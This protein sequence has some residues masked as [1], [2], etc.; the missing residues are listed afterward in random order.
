MKNLLFSRVLLMLAF[1]GAIL[2]FNACSESQKKS[3][4]V[5]SEVVKVEKNK[6]ANRVDVDKLIGS[7]KDTSEAGLD[8]LLLE[9]GSAKSLNSETLL[10][11]KWKL[12][13]N[14]LTL[15][16]KSIGNGIS[17]VDDETFVIIQLDDKSLA[18]QKGDYIVRYTRQKGC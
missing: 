14:Q 6:E 10:Y 15:T 3:E 1:A 8:I 7:W 9:D 17:F 4:E 2:M 11:T 13:G 12:N 5:S 18:L 16:S